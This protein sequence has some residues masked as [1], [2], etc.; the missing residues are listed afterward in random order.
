M[1]GSPKSWGTPKW[2]GGGSKWRGG[3]QT[4]G[5]TPQ[6]N[7]GGPKVVRLPQMGGVADNFGGHPKKVGVMMGGWVMGGVLKIGV[8]PKVR[9]V[10][11]CP[12]SGG[13]LKGGGV[14]QKWEGFRKVGGVPQKWGGFLRWGGSPK[15]KE[16]PEPGGRQL[17][18]PPPQREDFSP[19]NWEPQK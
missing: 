13:S 9:K 12:K 14:P 17:K 18:A 5:G 2:E 3:A 6:N 10:R 8:T 15:F 4:S 1:G 7:E 16:V 19:Q 11:G